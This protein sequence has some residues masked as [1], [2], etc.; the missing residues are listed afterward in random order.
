MTHSCGIV[1][2]I[3]FLSEADRVF[4][5]LVRQVT[6]HFVRNL[7]P[8]PAFISFPFIARSLSL[9]L[10]GWITW[11]KEERCFLCS[12]ALSV[13]GIIPHISLKSVEVGGG[14]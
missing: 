12:R 13:F 8:E 9:S 5:R 11:T 4:M 6:N 10:N 3:S 2:D 7:L 1:V 14:E